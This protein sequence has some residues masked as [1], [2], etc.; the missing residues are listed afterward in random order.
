M[1]SNLPTDF[2]NFSQSEHII[3][4]C[5]QVEFQISTENSNFVKYHLM[6]SDAKF[7]FNGPSALIEEEW[8]MK[9]F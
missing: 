3:D 6:N 2:W 8:N 1:K 7:G 5:I 4:P 9:G